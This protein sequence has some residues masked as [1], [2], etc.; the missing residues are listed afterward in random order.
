M[1]EQL[2]KAILVVVGI[3]KD[4]TPSLGTSPLDPKRLFLVPKVNR[5]C[6]SKILDPCQH[7]LL[8]YPFI[9]NALDLM[10]LDPPRSIICST[11]ARFTTFHEASNPLSS[12]A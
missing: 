3:L 9:E 6:F 8:G 10:I 11:Q 4:L 7:L 2:L 1:L 5:D 12:N